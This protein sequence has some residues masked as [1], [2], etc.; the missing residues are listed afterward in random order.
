MS[1]L[2]LELLIYLLCSP[3]RS[4]RQTQ[5]TL[6]TA[7]ILIQTPPSFST[8]PWFH[9]LSPFPPD[10][11]PFQTC[12]NVLTFSSLT[13]DRPPTQKPQNS[14]TQFKCGCRACTMLYFKLR[15]LEVTKNDKMEV[16]KMNE[17][18]KGVI[19]CQVVLFRLKLIW[20]KQSW[21]DVVINWNYP[22]GKKWDVLFVEIHSSFFV[23]NRATD[24][25][26]TP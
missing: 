2:F 17:M 22:L 19:K 16:M 15:R 14:F 7:F 26:K 20:L 25:K 3:H 10:L 8:T 11:S 4:D 9:H 18:K 12:T 21:P 23:C 1:Q 24:Y 6:T 13:R 5:L